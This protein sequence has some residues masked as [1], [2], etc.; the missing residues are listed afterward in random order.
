[1]RLLAFSLAI[2]FFAFSCQ[3]DLSDEQPRRQ[4]YTSLKDF[5]TKNK[6]ASQSFTANSATTIFLQGA[7]GSRFSFPSNAFVTM[8]NQPV[9]GEVSIEI[10]EILKPQEMI[11]SNMPTVSDGRPLESGGQFFIRVTKNN[12]ELKLAP[13]KQVQVT[14]QN[15]NAQAMQ[16]MQVFNGV[17]TA[18]GSVNWQLNTNQANVVRSDSTGSTLYT[19]FSDQV[20]WLNIDKFYNEP[21]ITYTVNVTNTPDINETVVYVHLT[22]RNTAFG[23]P[24]TPAG[25]TSDYLIAAQATL[26]AM[27]VK[28]KKL[29]YDMKPVTLQHGGSTNMQL[30]E[31]TEENL[32]ARLATLQ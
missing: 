15:V 4:V 27:C 12:E 30:I 19:M 3:A 24:R 2:T 6:V 18:N 17:V 23:F 29:Y 21:Q 10:K 9:S 28:D 11:L 25:F 16:G 5:Q 22:G 20:N 26:V 14:V 7:K 13:G 32:K 8:N 31:T 1:M